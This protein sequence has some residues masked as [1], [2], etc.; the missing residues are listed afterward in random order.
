M[1]RQAGR[2]ITFNDLS[3]MI[4]NEGIAQRNSFTLSNFFVRKD[5]LQNAIYADNQLIADRDANDYITYDRVATGIYADEPNP[6]NVP[7]SAG[8]T[9]ITVIAPNGWSIS[10]DAAWLTF[11]PTSGITGQEVTANYTLNVNA[12]TRTANVTLT[13]SVTSQTYSFQ[14]IQ[15]ANPGVPTDIVS[16]GYDAATSAAACADTPS[17]YWIPDGQTFLTATALYANSLGSVNAAAGYYSQ[18]GQWRLW[19]GSSF[20]LSGIC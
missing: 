13:D 20:T 18:A 6:L 11:S 19:N 8:S 17:D 16:L 15:A 12:S 7:F 5:A 4:S 1:A 14:I 2:F 3:F 9:D 10:D